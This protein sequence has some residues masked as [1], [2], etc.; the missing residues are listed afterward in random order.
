MKQFLLLVASAISISGFVASAHVKGLSLKNQQAMVASTD[1]GG[2]V[3]IL[4]D[5]DFSRMTAGSEAK[6]SEANIEDDN[7]Y[8]PASKTKIPG[9]MGYYLHE[10]GGMVYIGL[11]PKEVESGILMTPTVDASAA[12]GAYTVSFRA[13][14]AY[15]DDK[16]FVYSKAADNDY[17]TQEVKVT[18]E[19]QSYSLKFDNGTA[20]TSMMF[21]PWLDP[22][23]IDDIKIELTIPKVFAPKGLS[24]NNYT[25]L[26]FTAS[27][28][29]VEG[30]TGYMLSVYSKA[31]DGSR[32]YVLENEEVDGLSYDVVNLPAKESFYYFIVKATDGTDVSPES[33]EIVVEALLRPEILP[34]TDVT[35]HGFTANWK[36]VNL[37]TSYNFIASLVHTATSA[38]T[39]YYV[40]Q[41]FSTVKAQTAYNYT[42]V[43]ELPGWT[44]ASP[45]IVDGEIGVVTSYGQYGDDAWIQSSI[46]DFSNNNGDV[47]I[48][49]DVY[50]NH[51]RYTSDIL[52]GLYTYSEADKRF[53]VTEY[54]KYDAVGKDGV[55]IDLTLS[56]GGE[57]SLIM[58]QPDGYADMMIRSLKVSQDFAAGDKTTRT[59]HSAST[60]GTSMSVADID[61][62]E[63]DKVYYTIR[64]LGR[65]SI[66]TSNIYSDYTE[67]T[68]VDFQNAAVDEVAADG[69]GVFTVYNLQ[70][71][72]VL[73]TED[74]GAV[75]SL[76][77]GL[78]IIN[79]N[80]VVI[81]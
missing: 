75:K 6:P 57:Q 50:C 26:G 76:P 81:R 67:P 29:A 49:M 44:I 38:E 7:L 22:V 62:V 69:E 21:S 59:I 4:I 46:Y 40:D 39:Y 56:G 9:W 15:G 35:A 27:W 42:T 18:K 79:G 30:A 72:K 63:G 71:I 1:D 61:N 68:F 58:I 52:V 47:H 13:R 3:Q 33:V 43:K 28:E 66:D 25:G 11:D 74:A 34:E 32:E 55:M 78:Y 2:T 10:A 60:E 8:I 51:K 45:K 73:E 70:G 20:T 65:N 80:K 31:A 77:K 19:W 5:E 12:G 23:Y 53:K 24:F 17:T 16:F 64:A 14:A 48:E 41:D 54:K 36:P 37:A